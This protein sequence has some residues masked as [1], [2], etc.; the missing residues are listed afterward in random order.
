MSAVLRYLLPLP[1]EGDRSSALQVKI[2][3]PQDSFPC[4]VRFL[5]SSGA[6]LTSH[7]T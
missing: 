3:S 7:H 6:A 2:L 4:P 5:S 1:E